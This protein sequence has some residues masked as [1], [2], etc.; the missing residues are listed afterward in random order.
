MILGLHI[1]VIGLCGL[2]AV[3][4][5]KERMVTWVLFPLLGL[6]LAGSY[7]NQV[8]WVQYYPVVALNILLI[9]LVVLILFLYTQYIARKAFLNVSFGLGDLLFFYALALGFPTLTFL[10]VFAL[11]ILFA[12]GTFLVLNR[13]GQQETV[14]LAGLMGVFLCLVVLLSLFPNVPSL[15]LL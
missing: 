1:A 15:Y 5:F 12:L 9:S 2:I 3:Q 7:L 6:A 4:D 8:S 11:S 14:P 10:V 13:K